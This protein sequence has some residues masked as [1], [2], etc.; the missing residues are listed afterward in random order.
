MP[1]RGKKPMKIYSARRRMLRPRRARSPFTRNKSGARYD[2]YR[3]RST[4]NAQCPRARIADVWSGFRGTNMAV[5]PLSSGFG[6]FARVEFGLGSILSRRAMPRPTRQHTVLGLYTNGFLSILSGTK[7]KMNITHPRN[8]RARMQRN[9]FKSTFNMNIKPVLATVLSLGIA[10]GSNAPLLA[11]DNKP[12]TSTKS[13]VAAPVAPELKVADK[14]LLA[15]PK[16]GF[17]KDYLFTASLI[18]QERAATS[19]GLAGKIVRFELYPDGVDMY[20]S[21][22][23]LVVTDDLPSRRLL[24]SFSIVRTE[25][26]AVV[27]DFNK[28]MHRVFTQSWT[29]GGSFGGH[30]RVLD[31]PESRVFEMKQ[32]EGKLIIRQSVQ[33][34][35]RQFD[36]NSEQRYEARYFISP[37]KPE[38]FEGKEPSIADSRYTKFFETEGQIETGTGR[39][40]TRIARFDIRKPIVFYYSANTPADYVEAVKDGILYWNRAFEKEV[41]QVKKAPDGVT[42]PDASRNI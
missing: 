20:E 32:E 27:V 28:G 38:A 4:P 1:G 9:F 42:A 40:S 14:F 37:Y 41:I 12:E 18:P 35:N 3:A 8:V 39:M 11:A 17:G 10:A 25:S 16:S 22:K 5:N 19:T 13:T 26:D 29:E 31:V 6:R 15:I 23:G 24:A 34:R 33:A 7:F 30:D 21:T 2:F 36:Q